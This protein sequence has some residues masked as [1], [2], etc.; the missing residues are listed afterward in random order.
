MH[1]MTKKHVFVLVYF[2]NLYTIHAQYD[3]KLVFVLL[4]FTG[5]F[6]CTRLLEFV[7]L[8]IMLMRL[9]CCLGLVPWQRLVIVMRSSYKHYSTNFL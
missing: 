2:T 5:I 6:Q 8:E 1:T 7:I 3:K 4:Y 9:G